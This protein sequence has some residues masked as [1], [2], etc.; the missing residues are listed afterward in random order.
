MHESSASPAEPSAGVPSTVA[1]TTAESAEADADAV[2][3]PM[4]E[5][6]TLDMATTTIDTT[7]SPRAGDGDETSELASQS[8]KVASMDL[9][10][11]EPQSAAQGKNSDEVCA[12]HPHLLP[13]D[14][15]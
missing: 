6:L 15:V 12:S 5:E 2:S 13:K 8:C 7:T 1:P 11:E 4:S 9:D 10:M 3:E 14:I